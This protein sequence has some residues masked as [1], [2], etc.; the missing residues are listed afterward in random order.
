[1]PEDAEELSYKEV[2]SG[3]QYEEEFKVNNTWSVEYCPSRLKR[4]F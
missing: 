3:N 4:N 1:M 2:C